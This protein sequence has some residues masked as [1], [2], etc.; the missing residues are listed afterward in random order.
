M[1]KCFCTAVIPCLLLWVT[2]F[3][4]NAGE[5][6]TPSNFKKTVATDSEFPFEKGAH[7]VQVSAGAFFGLTEN[8]DKRPTLHYALGSIRHGWMLST[9]SGM[10][11]LRGNWEFLVDLFGGGVFDGPSGVLTGGSLLLRYNVVQPNARFVPYL[12]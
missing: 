6:T 12:Q 10:G 8:T 1:R 5:V 3:S 2:V 9:P 4:S 7:E 11:F